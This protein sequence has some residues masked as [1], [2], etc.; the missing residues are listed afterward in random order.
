MERCF[1]RYTSCDISHLPV[2]LAVQGSLRVGN[3]RS[4]STAFLGGVRGRLEACF[5]CYLFTTSGADA[6]VVFD[7]GKMIM[8][9]CSSV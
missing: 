5:S 1:P 2:T 3:V 8:S 7:T 9:L 6:A 4:G